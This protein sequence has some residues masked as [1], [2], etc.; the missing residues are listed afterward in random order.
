V[1]SRYAKVRGGESR[2]TH[3]E[4]C[5]APLTSPGHLLLRRP[6]C[7]FRRIFEIRMSHAVRK[8]PWRKTMQ[9][10]RGSLDFT[11]THELYASQNESFLMQWVFDVK[12]AFTAF[13]ERQDHDTS[14]GH[15]VRAKMPS[16]N[17][18]ASLYKRIKQVRHLT[19]ITQHSTNLAFD[20]KPSRSSN[21]SSPGKSSGSQTSPPSST[22]PYASTSHH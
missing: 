1:R 12:T 21:P 11:L 13:R 6:T 8:K 9:T 2:P 17:H 16:S 18:M 14:P 3:R 20:Y 10:A 22:Q 15:S 5:N 19:P 7:S 4:S